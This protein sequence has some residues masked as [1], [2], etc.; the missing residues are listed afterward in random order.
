MKTD[1]SPEQQ[2]KDDIRKEYAKTYPNCI[3]SLTNHIT[4]A[5]ERIVALEAEIA[6]KDED[7]VLIDTW[8][9][10]FLEKLGLFV[11]RSM[12]EGP[13][14][15]CIEGQISC[16]EEPVPVLWLWAT[17]DKKEPVARIRELAA[18]NARLRKLV[19]AAVSPP[20]GKVPG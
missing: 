19:E 15:T 13:L 6:M 20:T 1:A 4:Q 10:D 11:R 17:T 12:V 9:M 16:D 8:G 3:F 2:I 5:Q 14:T 7:K 18:D